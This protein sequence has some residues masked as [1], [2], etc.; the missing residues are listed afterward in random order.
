MCMAKGE[1]LEERLTESIIAAFYQVYNALG[2]G[3]LESLY[4]AAL[5]IELDERGHQVMRELSVD[6]F[7]K[8]KSIGRQR[9]DMVVD[10]K[11]VVE[12]KST[13]EL[14]PIATRQ[15]FSYL[16]AS[17]YEIGLVLHFGAKPVVKRLVCRRQEQE[18]QTRSD[19]LIIRSD[20]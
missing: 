1:L 2:F 19:P 14:H 9:L 16:R 7:Y 3:L 20:P 10:G 8:G 12:V 15:C 4:R 11:V 17:R 6:V 5:A 13:L 18:Q